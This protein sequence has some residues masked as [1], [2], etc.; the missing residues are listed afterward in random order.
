MVFAV[1]VPGKVQK[2]K[3]YTKLTKCLALRANNCANELFLNTNCTT[4]GTLFCG[5]VPVR[6][7]VWVQRK[8]APND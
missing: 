2:V 6:A 8:W 7:W 1:V 4:E 5:F 3:D